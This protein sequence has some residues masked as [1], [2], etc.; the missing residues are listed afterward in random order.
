MHY[1]GKFPY[2]IV[3]QCD[4]VDTRQLNRH[5]IDGVDLELLFEQHTGV[6]R[7]S[8]TQRKGIKTKD[9]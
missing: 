5:I 1:K 9:I 7:I 2:C 4:A 6:A 3:T 8:D